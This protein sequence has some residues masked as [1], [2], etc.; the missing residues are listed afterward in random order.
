MAVHMDHPI[1]SELLL[2]ASIESFNTDTRIH[3]PGAATR[4]ALFRDHTPKLDRD[5]FSAWIVLHSK[6]ASPGSE[7]T[8]I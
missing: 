8:S 7:G 6:E 2:L 5:S 1:W 4:K 3:D